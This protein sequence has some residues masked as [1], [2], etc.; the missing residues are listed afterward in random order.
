MYSDQWLETR[1]VN[2]DNI[3]YPVRCLLYTLYFMSLYIYKIL[4]KDRDL[5]KRK[6]NNNS[7]NNI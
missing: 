2:T 6:K 3:H 7:K 1:E 4:N 5:I